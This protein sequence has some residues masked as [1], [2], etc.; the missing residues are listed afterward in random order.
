M[1]AY[2]AAVTLTTPNA[3]KFGNGGYRLLAG[4]CTISNYNSTLAEISGISKMFKSGAPMT[5]VCDV[6]TNG[7]IVRWDRTSKAFK[8]FYPTKAI[9]PAGTVAAPTFT[10]SAL[11]GHAHKSFTAKGSDAAADKTAFVSTADGAGTAQAGV[12]VANAG[13]GSDID[14]NSSSVS[15]GT[16]AGTNSAPA[17]TGSAV[18]AQAGTEVAND[19]NVGTVNFIA[20]GV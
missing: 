19:V 20:F 1:G 15:A 12:F 6:S 9:T 10:G 17:F 3:A 13:S 14:F 7:Y 2:A 4:Q 18:A 16:P 8:C 11:S 5:V